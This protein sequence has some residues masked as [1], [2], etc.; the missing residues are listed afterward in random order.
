VRKYR[1][2]Y[3]AE[4]GENGYS[5]MLRNPPQVT[6]GIVAFLAVRPEPGN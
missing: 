4:M 2:K 1:A 3:P 5:T 6:V